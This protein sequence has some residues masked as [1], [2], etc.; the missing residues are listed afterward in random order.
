MGDTFAVLTR[1]EGAP[2]TLAQT[3]RGLTPGRD[4]CLQ[5]ATFDVTD[6]KAHR[7][8]PRRFGIDVKLGAGAAVKDAASWV[9]VD[10]RTKGRY[11]FNNN[12]AR[13]NLH[14]LVFT[15]RAEETEIVFD[16][17][18]AKVGE[19]LG[20]NAVSLNPYFAGSAGDGAL[21]S[22]QSRHNESQ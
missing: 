4:Y 8:A 19:V 12:M 16:N 10:R 21:T 18:A 2:A 22:T 13:I 1:Q 3:A 9:H 5:F 20:I 7:I 11:D 17:A 15:A 6:V 14:H